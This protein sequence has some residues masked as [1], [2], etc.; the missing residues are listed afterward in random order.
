MIN[1]MKRTNIY[2]SESQV[3]KLRQL[4]SLTGL[5]RAEHIRRAIDEY[6]VRFGE[7]PGG[8]TEQQ[9]ARKG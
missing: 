2:L 6:L 1:I 7:G 8:R 3:A 4:V 5:S 9:T